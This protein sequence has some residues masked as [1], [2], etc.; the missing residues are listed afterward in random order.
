MQVRDGKI[1]L[2]SGMTYRY[3]MLPNTDRLTLVAAEK[4]DEL[5]QAGAKIIAQ[6]RFTGT[7]SL[8][9]Y[10]EIEEK[11][12]QIADLLWNQKLIF[13]E[14]NPAQIFSNDNLLPDFEGEGLNYIHRK[15]DEVDFYFVANP[16]TAVAKINCSFRI[17][18]KIP[19]LWN[20][21]T[22]EIRELPEYRVSE[23]RITL[24]LHF[25]PMQSWFVVFRKKK[26][27]QASGSKNFPR[28]F[29]PVKDINGPWQVTF[30]P[31]GGGPAKPVTFENLQDWSK[32]SDTG[33]RFYSGTATYKNTFTLTPSQI[34]RSMTLLLDLGRTEVMARVRINGK[35]CGI[36]WKLP[37]RV[38]ITTAVREGEN[39]LEIDV[40]NTWVNRMIGDEF[41]PEDCDWINW[42][43]LKKWPD[44]FLNNESRP[45]GRYTFTSA[46]PYTKEDPLL[47]SGLLGPV[48]IYKTVTEDKQ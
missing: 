43:V 12:N 35:D 6:K 11:V 41:L 8:S 25:G 44:W 15:K 22:G 27:T 10:P 1:I 17:S 18:G 28:H 20:P 45:S 32:N 16:D 46:K 19:E 48:K 7:P 26:A 34:A 33:I 5:A 24:T 4:I 9:G 3:L 38:D 29:L 23:D 47:P 30:D 21:E 14:N 40:V 39:N 37:Y 13:T 31:H 42:E 36:A 2:P